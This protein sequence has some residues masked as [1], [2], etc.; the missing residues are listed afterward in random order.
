M[1]RRQVSLKV[2]MQSYRMHVI[3]SSMSYRSKVKFV[4]H[5]LIASSDESPASNFNLKC[6]LQRP[7]IKEAFT[8]LIEKGIL[9]AD[10]SNSIQLK[11]AEASLFYL[12]EEDWFLIG[13]YLEKDPRDIKLYHL[14]ENVRDVVERVRV[15]K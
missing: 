13:Y 12:T 10:L 5:Y 15:T 7:F 8:L 1:E 4:R 3:Y 2:L 14:S 11:I 6:L 9:K